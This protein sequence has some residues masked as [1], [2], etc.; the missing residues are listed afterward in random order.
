MPEAESRFPRRP[1]RIELFQ[2]VRPFYFVTF[3]TH[4]RRPVLATPALHAA[5][6][7]FCQRAYA[8]HAIAV[9]RYVLMPDHAHLFVCLPVT[10]A[11]LTNWVGQLK[12]QLGVGLGAAGVPRPFWQEG[13]FDHV[14]RTADSYSQ[15]WDYVRQNPVRAGLCQRPEDWPCQG[16]IVPLRF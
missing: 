16:E 15:K 13:F 1:P 7:T 14:M 2:N 4:G 5:F 10:G 6:L 8:G 11:S 3:N 9:G 12:R